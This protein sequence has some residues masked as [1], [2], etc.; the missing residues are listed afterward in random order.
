MSDSNQ[1][2]RSIRGCR[3]NFYPEIS[4]SSPRKSRYLEPSEDGRLGSTKSATIM[5]CRPGY[6]LRF[7]ALGRIGGVVTRHD[8]TRNPIPNLSEII[9]GSPRARVSMLC[10]INNNFAI[11]R[12]LESRLTKGKKRWNIS[13][14]CSKECVPLEDRRRTNWC[15]EIFDWETDSS[16]G[17]WRYERELERY[18][19]IFTNS[20]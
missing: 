8:R 2:N 20:I 5:S 11:R 18:I 16:R 1:S 4:Q 7:E 19:M 6:A 13:I 15:E 3:R 14:S 12:S 9:W 17:N 10:G